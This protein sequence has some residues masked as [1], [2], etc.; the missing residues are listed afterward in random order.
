MSSDCLNHTPKRCFAHALQSA[1]RKVAHPGAISA[2]Q[3]LLI[4]RDDASEPFHTTPAFQHSSIPAFQHSSIPAFQHSSIPAFPLPPTERATLTL[5]A[6]V[7]TMPHPQTTWLSPSPLSPWPC[8]ARATYPCLC[9]Y[10]LRRLRLRLR[11]HPHPCGRSSPSSS[12][13]NSIAARR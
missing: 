8:L 11:P 10:L 2:H 7:E 5:P 3:G 4:S 6:I 12:R 13:S 9:P 1:A